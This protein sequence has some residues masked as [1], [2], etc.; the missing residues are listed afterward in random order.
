MAV[1]PRRSNGTASTSPVDVTDRSVS[2]GGRFVAFVSGDNNLVA[3]DQNP[4]TDV[5]VRD[6]VNGT[7]SLVTLDMNGGPMNGFAS[8]PV[9]TPNGRYVAFFSDA[10]DLVAD[11]GNEG[12]DVFVRDMQTGTTARASAGLTPGT[13]NGGGTCCT[14]LPGISITP[15]GRYVA[16]A[17]SAQDLVT[18]PAPEVNQSFN[19]FRRDLQ[20]G[21]TKQIT[22]DTGGGQPNDY[23]EHPAISDDGKRIA[24][25]SLASD[26][27]AGDG[28]GFSDVFVYDE[29]TAT[30]SRASVDTSGGDPNETSA[31][32]VISGN[33]RY[34]AFW[35]SASDLVAG[36]AGG[37]DVFVRDLTTNSTA[38]VSAAFGGGNS[39]GGAVD[40][41]ITTD[42]TKI[43]FVSWASDL[44]TGDTNGKQDVFVRDMVAGTTTLQSLS[45]GG[46]QANRDSFDP[47]ISPEGGFVGFRTDATNLDAGKLLVR[48]IVAPTVSSVTP[49]TISA[50]TTDTFTV[51]GT[52]FAPDAYY[53]AFHDN[54][55]GGF[56]SVGLTVGTTTIDNAT[57]AHV[58]ISVD[59][60][61]A[62]G[63]LTLMVVNPGPGP[64][65]LPGSTAVCSSCPQIT[66]T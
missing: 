42:G 31:D 28:N 12:E 17:S 40:P 54:G 63:A 47:S 1:V 39:N 5:F 3:N 13:N 61:V 4:N 36:D 33:G 46:G 14:G 25:R 50:G 44:V 30:I 10:S 55:S 57:T 66:S 60:G 65:G 43:A 2:E 35:T 49:N 32:P 27:V 64:G 53:L 58:Q 26:L 51:T 34:V 6:V 20:L 59:T 23:S 9:I 62:P 21:V 52:D 22:V 15:D 38:K 48:A 41:S 37:F 19:I 56:T 18:T 16:F 29:T 11:D 45:A 8:H 24:F 7:T